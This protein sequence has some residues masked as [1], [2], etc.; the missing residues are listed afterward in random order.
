MDLNIRAFRAMDDVKIRDEYHVGL[1]QVL[2]YYGVTRVTS[3]SRDW[4][5]SPDTWLVVVQDREDGTVLGGARMQMA[6]NDLPLPIERAVAFKDT[7]IYTEVDKYREN[8]LGE[9]CGLW[10]SR[11]VAGMGLGS[12]Y[13]GIT[14]V[15]I[16]VKIN[17]NTVMCLCA[18][19]TKQNCFRVGFKLNKELGVQGEFVYPKENLVATAL[20]I[21]D[22]LE[23][24]EAEEFEKSR[25]LA[26]RQNGKLVADETTP[27]GDI[28]IFYDI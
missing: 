23:I 26:L 7:R 3:Q 12:I 24:P 20:I 9:L 25:I 5:D 15:S 11:K 22:P 10:N 2:L 17:M 8:G 1:E 18:P 16:A 19:S 21:N 6:S 28:R 27:R 14:C 4:F 13:L